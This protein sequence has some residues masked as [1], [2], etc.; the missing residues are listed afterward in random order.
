MSVSVDVITDV[1]CPWCI[2]SKRQLEKAVA[3]FDGQVKV[4]WLPF[5]L[6]T[7]M[8]REGVSRMDYR[9]KKFGNWERSQELDARVVAMGEADGIHFAFDR[10]GR[11]PRKKA[12]TIIWILLAIVAVLVTL[13]FAWRWASRRWSLPCPTFLAWSLESP[14]FQGLSGTETTLNQIGFRPGQKILEIGP[15]QAGYSFQRRNVF[16]QEAKRLG[17]TFSRGW[18]SA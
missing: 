17:L 9:T 2:I 10:I 4:R 13:H 14:L 12:V 16:S 6:N 5:Q 7:T 15:D 3:A 18:S 8:P 1:I 11:T